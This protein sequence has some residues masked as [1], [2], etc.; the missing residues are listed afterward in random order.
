MSEAAESTVNTGNN[1]DAKFVTIILR[2]IVTLVGILLIAYL[3][4]FGIIQKMPA[5]N[6]EAWGQFGDYFGGLMNPA[7]SICTLLVAIRVFGEQK[8][9]IELQKNAFDLQKEE[10][11]ATRDE[12]AKTREAADKQA[13]IMRYQQRSQQ[14]FDLMKMYGKTF[15]DANQE[16]NLEDFFIKD[17]NH[18][19]DAL[20]HQKLS[21]LSEEK[22]FWNTKFHDYFLENAA[23]IFNTYKS[24]LQ[25]IKSLFTDFL[26]DDSD[27]N[28]INLFMAQLKRSELRLMALC[29]MKNE[30][31]KASFISF[32]AKHG[33]LASLQ[34]DSFRDWAESVLP[35]EC[36]SKGS[37]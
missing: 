1:Y 13:E 12:L 19:M 17:L 34:K 5:T 2:V 26:A 22:I 15:G 8:K 37:H 3:L 16:R 31:L 25:L 14:F 21:V 11:K 9:A 10:L 32:S 33:L 23:S 36:F 29:M 20:R 27:K 35:P 18:S 7:I 6:P 24:H 4:V 28:F 30:E